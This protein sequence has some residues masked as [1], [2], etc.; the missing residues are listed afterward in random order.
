MIY[1][2]TPNTNMIITPNGVLLMAMELTMQN[3]RML[4]INTLLATL[5]LVLAKCVLDCGEHRVGVRI[6]EVRA[7]PKRCGVGV[8]S[9]VGRA[10][11]IIPIS[12]V[13]TPRVDPSVWAAV[14]AECRTT[15]PRSVLSVA[16]FTCYMTS[17][18]LCR[19]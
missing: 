1:A 12:T 13:M 2:M 16:E 11:S 3:T 18:V 4:G 6:A 15:P 14:M 5:T 17:E 9:S 7:Q 10:Q 19:G 8:V